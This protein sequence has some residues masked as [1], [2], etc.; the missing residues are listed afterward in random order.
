M[1]RKQQT[2]RKFHFLCPKNTVFVKPKIFG[3]LTSQKAQIQMGESVAII[4]IVLI[5][6]IFGLV[7]FSKLK[8]ININEKSDF[9]DELDAITTAH[10]AYSLPETTCSLAEV[11]DYGCVD[12]LKFIEL[13]KMINESLHEVGDKHIYFYY[14]E[15]FG[16]A[17]ISLERIDLDGT[18]RTWVLYETNRTW[19]SKTV[20]QMPTL[21]Y[22]PI[23]E[24]NSFAVLMVEKYA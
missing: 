13:S 19:N 3:L 21:L 10:I 1:K 9:F 11:P 22:N 12:M 18:T 4:V 14:R 15:L 7:F 2:I 23:S 6:I 24:N 5:L 8:A 16:T 20:I 17:K